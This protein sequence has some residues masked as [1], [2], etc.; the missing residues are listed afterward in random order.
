MILRLS[1][2][3]QRAVFVAASFAVALFLSYFSIR[4]ALASH[5]ADLQTAEAY[6]R[7]VRVSL[8][9]PETGISWAVTGSTTSRIPTLCARFAP[10]FRLC[11]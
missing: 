6:E 10:T 2:N 5:Y 7:A 4:N 1:S 8:P 11:R 9:T 3:A